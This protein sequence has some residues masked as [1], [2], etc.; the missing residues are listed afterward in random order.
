M[1][2]PLKRY[3]RSPESTSLQTGQKEVKKGG[4]G[5]NWQ[6]HGR[7]GNEDDKDMEDQ[8]AQ[9]GKEDLS[10]DDEATARSSKRRK[11]ADMA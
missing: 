9:S 5:E 1:P 11:V 7:D 4:K 8:G 3:H 2:D 6:A 10:S